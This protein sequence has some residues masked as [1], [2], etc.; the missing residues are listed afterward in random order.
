MPVLSLLD[1]GME[2]PEVYEKAE[3]GK[4]HPKTSLFLYDDDKRPLFGTVYAG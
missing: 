4:S 1:G 3:F 2:G